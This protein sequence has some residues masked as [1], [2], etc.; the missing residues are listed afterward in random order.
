MFYLSTATCDFKSSCAWH[1]P[2][3]AVFPELIFT[4]PGVCQA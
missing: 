3:E 4:Q 2:N 1:H